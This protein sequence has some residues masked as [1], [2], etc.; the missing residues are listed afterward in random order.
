[1]AQKH[2]HRTKRQNPP[3]VGN[4]RRRLRKQFQDDDDVVV[5][6]TSPTSIIPNLEG[7]DVLDVVTSRNTEETAT[8]DIIAQQQTTTNEDG[9]S[10]ECRVTKNLWGSIAKIVSTFLSHPS[11]LID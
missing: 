3:L 2:T 8:I 6:L 7:M 4:K 9:T 1:M 5:N 11:Y 10:N